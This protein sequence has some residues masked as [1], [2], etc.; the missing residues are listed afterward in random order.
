MA[1]SGLATNT[2]LEEM[3]RGEWSLCLPGR[4]TA[5]W[6]ASHFSVLPTACT[7]LLLH[8]LPGMPSTAS[9]FS[10]LSP[11][12]QQVTPHPFQLQARV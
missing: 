8:T 10:S 5:S 4:A 3:D 12:A 7:N 11:G 9:A 1:M 2:V 6:Q